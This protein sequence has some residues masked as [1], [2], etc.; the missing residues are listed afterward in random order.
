[1]R[2]VRSFFSVAAL[3]ALAAL[4]SVGCA[5]RQR[6]CDARS[7][8]PAKAA[9]VA[10]RCQ[11]EGAEPAIVVS[12]RVVVEPVAVAYLYRGDSPSGGAVPSLFTMGRTGDG[13]ELLL[14]RFEAP[15]APD[16]A[17][18]EAYVLLERSD[19]MD[20]DPSP[21]GLYAE[22]VV[23]PW[24]PRSVSWATQPPLEDVRAPLTLMTP[25]SGRPFVRVDVRE[26]VEAWRHRD[27]R[28]QGIAIVAHG[29][30]A[31]GA[32]FASGRL[33]LYVK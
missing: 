4:A 33:E 14:L 2:T 5:V 19:A 23:G 26:L 18:V 32:T 9:C 16:A 25:A 13:D 24:D 29:A 31:T 20:M 8:C 27:P 21:I 17:V 6:M 11:R 15:L 3:A 7:V 10:G 1:V 12:R 22:R 30:T 28:D